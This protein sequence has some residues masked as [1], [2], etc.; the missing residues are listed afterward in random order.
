MGD[1]LDPEALRDLIGRY[2]QAIAATVESHGGTVREFAGDSV[3][4]VFGIPRVHEDD[5]V[6]AVRAAA[7]IRER[8][9]LVAE[10]IGVTLRLRTGVNTG[11]VLTDEG[12]T[13][14]MGDAVNVAARLE[15]A[16]RPG[17]ILL[18]SETLRLVRD[19]VEV[20]PLEPLTVKGK[21]EPV[22]AFRLL[23][24]DPTAPGVARRLDVPLVDREREL[25]L[26]REVW[27]RTMTQ[28]E[29]QM[30]TVVGA[31]G[32]GKSRL[33]E[34]MLVQLERRATTLRGRCL[35]YGEG[36]TF[37]PIFEALTGAGEAGEP[38]VDRL[39][40]GGAATPQELFWEVRQLL[41][42]LA[43]ERPVILHVDDMQWAEPMLVELLDH[44]V[45]LSHNASILVLCTA[46][47]ELLEDNAGWRA[48]KL[49]TTTIQLEPLGSAD[50][51]RLLD[52]FGDD[53]SPESRARVVIRSEGNPL[54]LREMVV[55]A[56][57]GGAVEIP[58]SIQAL[59]L[60]RL[61]RLTT[62]ERE[63][64]ECAAVEGQVFHRSAVCGLARRGEETNA[65]ALLSGLVRKDLIE[66]HPANVPGDHAFRF[67]HLLIRDA[68]YDRLPK[69]RRAALHV[70]YAEWLEGAAV[71]F[72]EVDE[73]AGWH[74]EQAVLYLQ[75]LARPPDPALSR[76]GAE[77]LCSAGQRAADR[78][79]VEAARNLLQRAL[80][81]APIG[82][83][84]HARISAALAERLIE[85]GDLPGADRLL[86]WAELD[87]DSG[88]AALSRL[89]WLVS[90][91]PDAARRTIES[92]LPRMLEQL[93]RSSDDRGLA[94]AH[95][96]AFWLRWTASQA[97]LAGEEVRL[98]AEHARKGGDVGLS[99]RALGWYVATLIYG[100]QDAGMISNEL[101]AIERESPG[102][103]L[104]AYVD[105]GRAEVERLGR[106][107]AEARRLSQRA[108]DCF[109][110]L[111]M[112]TMVATCEQSAAW[113]ELAAGDPGAAVASLLR[114][115]TILARLGERSLRSTT[116]AMLARVHQ[117]LGAPE[118]ALAAVDLA[119]QLSA[120]EDVFNFAI[121]HGVRAQLA[122]GG[123]DR[124]GAERW[125]RSA[126]DQALNTDFLG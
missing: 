119:E 10:D 123:G 57:D 35:H 55:L 81:L 71:D 34:E 48:G 77:H 61:E 28:S 51:E 27:A 109:A 3:F 12:R 39:S 82:D 7:E 64:L 106:R 95:M 96:L 90:A 53:L 89:E 49:N 107:F 59:L 22:P 60:A 54:F 24:V 47:P 72:V 23:S 5:A 94:K 2:L 45:D 19:A 100:P 108:L 20:E 111:G 114:S 113:I 76:R 9:R 70:E 116:Q 44:V 80:S 85:V 103:Y 83:A 21:A 110:G 112:R 50:C 66:R 25:R 84:L 26:L 98:A 43:S 93:A 126:L 40:R 118:A 56:R 120:P 58:S 73:I 41:E 75:D 18:G 14:V 79:D 121:T 125:A 11:L 88:A 29:C 87:D 36:I 105:L 69:A 42:R 63:L 99:S 115:D 32:V 46:R 92:N 97:T 62:D 101:D 30:F 1:E 122:L 15:Q 33:V 37:W 16:A 31:A 8:S 17:E 68:A 86:K 67:R 4:A 104:G 6:R 91:Q 65:E 102:P 124:V 78:S 38:I 117:T 13:L 52:E 74:F